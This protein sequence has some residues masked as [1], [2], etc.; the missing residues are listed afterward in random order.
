M[1]YARTKADMLWE[2]TKVNNGHEK[3]IVRNMEGSQLPSK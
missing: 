2:I 1:Y 3:E